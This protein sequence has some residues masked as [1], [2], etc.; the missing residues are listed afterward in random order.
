MSNRELVLAALKKA[1]Q[2]A[3]ETA[4]RTNTALVFYENGKVVKYKP[5]YRFELVPIKTPKKKP[6]AKKPRKK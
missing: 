6:T 2:T 4:V 5:P 3:F 1:Y